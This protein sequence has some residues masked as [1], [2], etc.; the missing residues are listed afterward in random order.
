MGKKVIDLIG[1][2]NFEIGQNFKNR[3]HLYLY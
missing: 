3:G 2:L 1:S